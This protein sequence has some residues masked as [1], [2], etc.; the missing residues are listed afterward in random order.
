MSEYYPNFKQ[1][2]FEPLYYV[3]FNRGGK[4]NEFTLFKR[5][6]FNSQSELNRLELDAPA[7]G[8]FELLK[9]CNEVHPYN[10]FTASFGPDGC[11]PDK[12]W[13]KFMVDALNEKVQNKQYN[14]A[15]DTAIQLV[16]E[17]QFD[18]DCAETLVCG[19]ENSKK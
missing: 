7:D 4:P 10:L 12:N 2:S 14:Q 5:H 13:V 1:N 9:M 11:S 19:L 15:I 16:I 18:C 17:S 6:W 8:S 3:E